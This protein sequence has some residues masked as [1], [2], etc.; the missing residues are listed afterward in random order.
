M[1]KVAEVVSVGTELLF[2]QI[3]DTNAQAV[4][5]LLPELGIHHYFRQTVGDNLERL[6]TAL[7]LALSRSDIVFTIGGL[8]PTEDD[9]TRQGIAAALDDE[10]VLDEQIAEKLR[11]LFEL[12]KLNWTENQNRQSMRPRCA[13]PLD[14]PN[15]TAP[16]LICE[17]N[18]KSVIALPGPKGE[19]VPLLMG[20]V[21]D[22]L[23]QFSGDEV[24]HS[25]LLKVCGLGESVVET[26]IRPLLESSNPSVAPYA[27]LGE[28]HLRITAS[29]PNIQLAEAMIEPVE[30]R[31]RSVLGNAVFGADQATL[32]YVTLDLL[33]A[34]K[35]TL[36]VAE[37]IT[38][39]GLGYRISSVPGASECFLGGIITYDK[40]VKQSELGVDRALLEDPNVGP[41]SAEVAVQMATGVRQK[42][43][44]DYGVSLTGNAGPTSD[45]GGKPVGLVYVAIAGP[46]GTR[47]EEYRFRGVREDI[48]YRAGQAA[49]T[50]LRQSL[51]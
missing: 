47:V 45:E 28:V 36:A 10:L 17:K 42:L 51:S 4:G 7:K 14:N 6:T 34:R 32:E 16:G 48:R 27:K 23:A 46:E 18:G 3:A 29:A 50:L 22:Y 44:A 33:K 38:G 8:G 40:S 41:V 43:G 19:F 35:Q 49:L 37:S 12:R 1:S 26:K 24:I 20:E 30:E 2:G 21:R 15:G 11:K 13:R 25:R 31:I 5:Q 9:L 39:G